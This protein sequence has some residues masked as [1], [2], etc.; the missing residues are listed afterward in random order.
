MTTVTHTLLGG[1]VGWSASVLMP[2]TFGPEKGPMFWPLVFAGV[3]NIPD[4]DIL[5]LLVPKRLRKSPLFNHRGITHGALA[6]LFFMVL[7]VTILTGRPLGCS[8]GCMIALW[9]L[10]TIGLH[11]ICDC[12]DGSDGICLFA[13]FWSC[14]VRSGFR[15]NEDMPLDVLGTARGR[16]TFLSCVM[17]ETL[18]VTVPAGLLCSLL[19]RVSA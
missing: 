15:I 12:L 2:S 7:F 3:S 6:A 13:P 1:V 11:L 8:R 4:I 9:F 14:K 19:S 5:L 17:I 16:A 10:G 18:V